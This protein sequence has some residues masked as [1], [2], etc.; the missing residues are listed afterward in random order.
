[1]DSATATGT[2]VKTA[3]PLKIALAYCTCFLLWG[4]TWSVV[5]VGLEDLPP[6]RFL[7]ARLL[8]TALVMLP[9]T[10][11]KGHLDARTAKRI[12]GL[13]MLQLAFPFGLLFFAQQWIPSSWAALLFSTFPVWLLFVGRVLMPDQPL[14]PGK[15][16][17]AGMGVGGVVILQS[18][19][20]QGMALSGKVLLGV[21]LALLSVAIIAVANV[22]IKRFMT[23]V[24]PRT[25]VFGQSLSSAVPLMALSLLLEPHSAAQWTPRA[26]GAVF[27]L[28]VFGTAF[29][30]LCL[31][32]LLPRISLTALGA[33][34]LLDTLV[35]VVMG[36]VFLDEPFTLSLVVGGT[37]IL[38]GAALANKLP[39]QGAPKPPESAPG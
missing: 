12:A 13:G 22:L 34:A 18:S 33:M 28:A 4:S 6:L 31:Y 27:Y 14:T 36:V 25:L 2:P 23:N 37:L 32:W 10:Q 16:L 24:P 5:K 26:M 30:Y 21:G 15:L 38:G 19:N 3:S 17:A 8:L 7:G 9:F 1:M 20:L 39:Q 29:T 11:L 35:A